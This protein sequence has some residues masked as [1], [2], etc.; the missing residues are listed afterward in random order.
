MDL[1]SFVAPPPLLW[2][3]LSVLVFCALLPY[4]VSAQTLIFQA[5]S[6][7]VTDP[8]MVKVPSSQEKKASYIPASSSINTELL[9]MIEQL[10]EEVQALRG[11]VEEQAQEIRVLKKSAKNRYL[12]LDK[13]ILDLSIK[14]ANQQ[15][16]N[17]KGAEVVAML[18]AVVKPI[19]T[20]TG[21]PG[22]TNVDNVTAESHSVTTSK[23][24]SSDEERRAYNEAYAQVKSR[25][26]DLAIK[27][28]YEFIDKYPDG[29]LAGNAYYWLGEVY[30]VVP[31]LEQ[32]EQAFSIVVQ[33]YQTHPK[34]ADALYKLGVTLDRMQKPKQSEEYLM[35]VQKRFPN[36]TASK[37]A[38]SYKINR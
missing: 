3:S 37:L 29:D 25:N 4:G 8:P 9:S 35:E 30:L 17:I 18:P 16:A 32:A 21:E 2:R 19:E 12:D 26:F 24:I 1:K 36:S 23:K 11:T 34:V 20:E 27:K 28:F 15:V 7:K 10:Q 6:E 22:L 14:A 31:Q 38:K 33:A 13:R 5:E